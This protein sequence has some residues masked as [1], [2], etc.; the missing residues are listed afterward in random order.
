MK[1]EALSRLLAGPVH[2]QP[3][4]AMHQNYSHDHVYGDSE[5]CDPAQQAE[6]QT[7]TSQKF[8]RNRQHREEFGD[9]QALGEH[10]HGLIESGAAKPP[11]GLLGAVRKKDHPQNHT[12]YHQRMIVSRMNYFSEPLP[13]SL[14]DR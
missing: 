7:D 8:R 5:G 4:P 3:V 2:E 12:Q 13:T 10:V 14:C 11:K 6:K 1:F 9:I